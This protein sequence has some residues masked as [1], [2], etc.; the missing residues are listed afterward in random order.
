MREEYN[1]IL[2]ILGFVLI[3]LFA[4][5]G[6]TKRDADYIARRRDKRRTAYPRHYR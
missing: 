2:L 5:I 1:A 4:L 6:A 3:L